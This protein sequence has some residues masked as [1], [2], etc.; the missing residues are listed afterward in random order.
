MKKFKLLMILVLFTFIKEVNAQK[1]TEIG[2]YFAPARVFSVINSRD[3]N[4]DEYV[5]DR[6]QND[7]RR[8]GVF[9]GLIIERPFLDNLKFRTGISF[10][11]YGSQSVRL[12]ATDLQK[13]VNPDRVSVIGRP[14]AYFLTIPFH[15]RKDIVKFPLKKTTKHMKSLNFLI[16]AIGGI[17]VGYMFNPVYLR[18]YELQSGEREITENE[19]ESSFTSNPINML[20]EAGLGFQWMANKKITVSIEPSFNY[21]LFSIYRTGITERFGAYSTKFRIGFIL[22]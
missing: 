12:G 16:Y 18:T 3:V 1:T 10:S 11:I 2:W 22:D 6:N 7:P 13:S 14:E 8:G 15:I 21:T 4:F 9:L 20:V 17:E 5:N 19:F